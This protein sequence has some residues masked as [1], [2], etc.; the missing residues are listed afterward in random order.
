MKR[1]KKV[2]AVLC[3]IS[4]AF[5][6]AAKARVADAYTYNASFTMT[7]TQ[8]DSAVKI[9]YYHQ[10]IEGHIY[11]GELRGYISNGGFYAEGLVNYSEPNVFY[12]S[13]KKMK[14]VMQ[15]KLT[16]D[17]SRFEGTHFADGL[18]EHSWWATRRP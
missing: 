10:P 3:M 18:G 13:R 4:V 7:I 14:I 9:A 15:G 8:K 12:T 2:A 17:W 11:R 1:R 16:D 5:V 6:L